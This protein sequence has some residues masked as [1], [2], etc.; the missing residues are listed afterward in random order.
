MRPNT[1]SHNP[2]AIRKPRAEDARAEEARADARIPNPPDRL[3]ATTQRLMVPAL[4]LVVFMV[5]AATG[6][7]GAWWGD[8]QELACA[9]WT[10]GIAHPPGYPLYTILGH[11]AMKA[12]GG[13]DPGRA[14]TLF[15]A[16][17]QALAAG[18]LITLYQRV[19][20]EGRPEAEKR[21]GLLAAT[22]AGLLIAFSRTVWDHGTFAEVLPL[23]FLFGALILAVAWVPAEAR[24]GAGRAAALGGLLGVALLNHY[25]ILA[26]AP[27]A[28][29]CVLRWALRAEKRGWLL[30]LAAAGCGGAAL[31]GYLYL[32]WRA[33]ANPA[34]NWGDPATAE[35]LK[36]MLSGGQ[37]KELMMGTDRESAA[38]GISNWL[39]WWGTL[40]LPAGW[41]RLW[42]NLAL[43]AAALGLALWGLLHLAL[44]RWE[45][46]LGLLLAIAATFSYAIGYH[47][48]DID[49]YFMIGLPAAM[50]GWIVAAGRLARGTRRPEEAGNTRKPALRTL[51]VALPALL[52]L[53]VA[54]AN[55]RAM[56]KSWDNGPLAYGTAVMNVLPKDALIVTRMKSDP[57]IFSL[58]YQQM[59]L[60]KRTDVTVL[61]AGFIFQGWYGRYFERPD[62]PKIPM[63][64]E[65]R[66]ALQTDEITYYQIFFQKILLPNLQQGR[67]VYTTYQ[68]ACLNEYLSPKPVA[69]VMKDEYFNYCEY[70]FIGLV[71]PVLFELHANP[72]LAAM[73][74]AQLKAELMAFAKRRVQGK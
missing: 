23:T 41:D 29:L 27:L 5:Y 72:R 50:A 8:G 26:V 31:L 24:P 19:L 25:S 10:L 65:E 57:E 37:F 9:A 73:N 21:G 70:P 71:S 43:G 47:I 56:D 52:A 64:I 66:P 12:L 61:G 11:G 34:L 3:L 46:G 69:R 32:P 38:R 7:P 68:D 39:Q 59:V 45:L 44:R 14:L 2:D 55:Y 53:T 49:G 54:L 28:A 40:W 63:H 17:C 15:S 30:P 16:L 22:G 62:R 48:Q 42:L 74:E 13:L 58:W 51:A 36:W 1:P 67:P 33:A 4:A 20:R 18:V 60:G 35:R 6:A